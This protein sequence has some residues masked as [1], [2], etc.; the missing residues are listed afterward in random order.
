MMGS[1]NEDEGRVNGTMAHITAIFG[2]T[3]AGLALRDLVG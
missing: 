2:H 3:L 1:R